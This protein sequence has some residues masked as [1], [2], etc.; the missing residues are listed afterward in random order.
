[1][2]GTVARLLAVV[3]IVCLGVS[4]GGDDDK[5]YDFEGRWSWHGIVTESNVPA[6]PIGEE[7][8]DTL[9]ISQDDSNVTVTFQSMGSNL[10]MVGT[11]DTK[12]RT[13]SASGVG[14]GPYFGTSAAVSGAGI[15]GDSMSGIFRLNFPGGRFTSGTWSAD[16]GSRA[17]QG[18]GGAEGV[19]AMV[20]RGTR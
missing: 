12:A 18:T 3:A 9:I 10:V 11:C 8:F 4:C 2:R 15:D 19:K 6:N 5:S 20:L 13:F 17:V 7:Y 1:M 14:T 16:L